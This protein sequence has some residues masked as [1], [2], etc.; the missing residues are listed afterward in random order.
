[1][2]RAMRPVSVAGIEFDALISEN[3]SLTADTPE[4]PIETGFVVSDSVILKPQVL[5]MTLFL[6]DTPISWRRRL[7]SGQG[8]VQYVIDRLEEAYFKRELVTVVTSDKTYTNMAI[9]GIT[10][11]KSAETGYAREI[12]ITFK[13]V[14]VTKSATTT[15]PSAYGKSGATGSNAGTAGTKTGSTPAPAAKN[16]TG[17]SSGG[18]SGA[19][20]KA[21]SVLYGLA[22][23]AGML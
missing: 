12:P 3:R 23:S 5:S 10:I 13:E 8:R 17:G 20:G 4:Y 2:G 14:R 7:G 18:G 21:G 19:S 9:T 15:I 6:T 22:A 1:M 16:K 11:A